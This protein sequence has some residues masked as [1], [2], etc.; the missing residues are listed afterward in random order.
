MSRTSVMDG[1][2]G[3]VSNA[4]LVRALISCNIQT[5]VRKTRCKMVH[6]CRVRELGIGRGHM[7]H[8]SKVGREGRWWGSF[9]QVIEAV[10]AGHSRVT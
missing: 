3:A 7:E 8:C 1:E 10:V 4:N 2:S 9:I 6:S 5:E